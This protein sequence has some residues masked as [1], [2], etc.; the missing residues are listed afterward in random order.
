LSVREP[1]ANDSA[2]EWLAAEMPP[3]YET[4]LAEIQ[5]LNDELRLMGR[6]GRLLWCIGDDLTK[7]ARDGFVELGFEAELAAG[8][9][10]ASLTVSVDAHRRLLVH[11]AR[12]AETIPK[13][14]PEL[15]HV[16]QLLH[17]IAGDTDRVVLLA[18]PSPTTPP[19]GRP[20]AV[21][22]EALDFLQRLAVNVVTGPTL[23]AL[24]TMSLQDRSRVHAYVE[25][26]HGQDG[27]M[28]QA[29]TAGA[30]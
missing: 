11:V 2:P 28:F 26:L 12:A 24:W 20:E 29:P 3:G 4:R 23:F 13:K 18:N 6:F 19:A 22:A 14:S 10:S 30:R 1:I 9:A 5:R 7:A 21:T 16:F 17:E 27:G 8:P 15:A 25:R